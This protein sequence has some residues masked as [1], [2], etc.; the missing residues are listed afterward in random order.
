M[1]KSTISMAIFNSYVSHYQRVFKSPFK[2]ASY[3][4]LR[5]TWNLVRS[6]VLSP[7]IP[8]FLMAHRHLRNTP[9]LYSIAYS[10]IVLYPSIYSHK[11]VASKATI[12]DFLITSERKKQEK[13]W[14]AMSHRPSR[15]SIWSPQRDL[16][17]ECRCGL[18]GDQH[19]SWLRRFPMSI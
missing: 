11:F 6:H 13:T 17:W 18:R 12:F 16:C 7:H 19:D 14:P 4:I 5:R 10:Y 8:P 9:R 15:A 1:E 2:R 3:P